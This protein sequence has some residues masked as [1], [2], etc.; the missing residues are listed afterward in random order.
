MCLEGDIGAHG[1]KLGPVLYFSHGK[2]GDRTALQ[3]YSSITFP[4]FF[5]A[6][7]EDGTAH[8]PGD[9][10]AGSP[11]R[12]IGSAADVP[13][14]S[15]VA[16]VN[17]SCFTEEDLLP[18]MH[19]VAHWMCKAKTPAAGRSVETPQASPWPHRRAP[20]S[21]FSSAKPQKRPWLG[22][23]TP[24]GG[25]STGTPRASTEGLGHIG[26]AVNIVPARAGGG[27]RILTA[28]QHGFTSAELDAA[29]GRKIQESGACRHDCLSL[30]WS[31]PVQVNVLHGAP[32]LVICHEADCCFATLFWL[33]Q[34]APQD[35]GCGRCAGLYASIES[36]MEAFNVWKMS[37]D[38]DEET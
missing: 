2:C 14:L 5:V 29:A 34:A 35:Q 36:R 15:E 6:F 30:L 12:A 25:S 10:E 13:F 8:Q 19:A 3:V 32:A 31:R 9:Q 24:G 21:A 27:M 4:Y 23:R 7:M 33:D 17:V 26:V 16:R 37:P 11:P 28:V 38:L 18:V 20:A 22:G 1:F